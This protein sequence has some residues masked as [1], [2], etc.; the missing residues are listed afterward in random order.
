MPPR[1]TAK[2]RKNVSATSNA[3]Y[4]DALS[5]GFML[6]Y[7]GTTLREYIEIA[8]ITPNWRGICRYRTAPVLASEPDAWLNFGGGSPTVYSTNGQKVEDLAV[9]SAF[10]GKMW[11]EVDVGQA[12]A[13]SGQ[14][15]EAT[16]TV[17]GQVDGNSAIV[18]TGEFVTGPNVN[19]GQVAYVPFGREFDVLGIAGIMAA[20]IVS[21][22]SGS[23]NYGLAIRY[24]TGDSVVPGPWLDVASYTAITADERRNTGDVPLTSGLLPGNTMRAQVGFKVSGN[25]VAVLKA[26]AAA[27]W[28]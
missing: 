3:G 2:P 20:F 4:V 13:N 17:Q 25:A 23:L 5:T 14:V 7:G 1:K 19:A 8:Q 28:A 9:G 27:R 24:I 22:V 21:G 11:V 10:A 15:G 12:T 18:A 6:A 16:I 26:V